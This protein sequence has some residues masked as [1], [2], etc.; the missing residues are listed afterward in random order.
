M[1]QGTGPFDQQPRAGSCLWPLLTL[2]RARWRS[3]SGRG[4]LTPM[5]SRSVF[6]VPGIC[7]RCAI[8]PAQQAHVFLL[9]LP[10][11]LLVWTAHGGGHREPGAVWKEGGLGSQSLGSRVPSPGRSLLGMPVF[12]F[13]THPSRWSLSF[14]T[15]R[16]GLSVTPFCTGDPCPSRLEMG[17]RFYTDPGNRLMLLNIKKYIKS[18]KQTG[19]RC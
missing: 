18:C 8:C 4:H 9:V 1:A 19:Q 2:C 16:G 6:F 5:R 12:A 13:R 14:P 3:L 10:S 15:K 7:P 17:V 11:L